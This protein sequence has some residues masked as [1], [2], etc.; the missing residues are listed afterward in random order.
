[1][2]ISWR[3][4]QKLQWIYSSEVSAIVIATF[5]MAAYCS[6]QRTFATRWAFPVMALYPFS[7]GVVWSLDTFLGW[8]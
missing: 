8:Q 4:L 2:Q 1:M 5:I 6:S 3:R 7:L